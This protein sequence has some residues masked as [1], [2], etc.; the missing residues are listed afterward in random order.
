METLKVSKFERESHYTWE[1][2]D[3]ISQNIIMNQNPGLYP[4]HIPLRDD[5]GN[6]FKPI[7]T[8]RLFDLRGRDNKRSMLPPRMNNGDMIETVVIASSH[9]AGKHFEISLEQ[10]KRRD[11]TF[12]RSKTKVEDREPAQ[13]FIPGSIPP[14]PKEEVVKV[15]FHT[16]SQTPN[17]EILA[18]DTETGR[19]VSTRIFAQELAW[20]TDRVWFNVNRYEP[21]GTVDRTQPSDQPANEGEQLIERMSQSFQT[22]CIYQIA[23]VLEPPARKRTWGGIDEDRLN[24]IRANPDT[25]RVLDNLI[26]CLDQDEFQFYFTSKSGKGYQERWETKFGPYMKDLFTLAKHFRNFWFYRWQ[27]ID[28]GLP[29]RGQA[30]LNPSLPEVDFVIPRWLVTQWTITEY[31]S[32]DGEVTFS[33]PKPYTWEPFDFPKDGYPSPDESAFLLKLSIQAEQDRQL[34]ELKALVQSNSDGSKMFWFRGR[35]RSLDNKERIYAVEVYLGMDAQLVDKGLNMPTP[36]TR[37]HLEVDR[38][39]AELPTRENTAK[40]DGVVVYDALETSASFICVVDIVG[41]ALTIADNDLEYNM[42]ISYIVDS[43]PYV[44]MLNGVAQ[45]QTFIGN[46]LGPDPRKTILDCRL[47]TENTDNQNREISETEF[48]TFRNVVQEIPPI[49]NEIQMKAAV[50]TLES[51][52]GNVVIVGPPGTGKTKT[53]LKICHGHAKLGRRIILS[54]PTNSTVHTLVDGF[55]ENNKK[56]RQDNQYQDH[57]WV[58]FTGGY[59]SVA[60]AEEL[61]QQ[62]QGGDEVLQRA[63][64]KLFSYLLDAQNRRHIPRYEQTLGYKLAKRIGVWASDENYDLSEHGKLYSDARSYLDTRQK[65]S[66]IQDK[67]QRKQAKKHIRALEYNLSIVFL[68][69]VKFCFCTLSTSGHEL[70]AESGNWD[71]LIID[72]AARETR[73]GLAVALGSLAGRIKLVVW[74]GDHKQG[75]APVMGKNMNIGH[76]LLSRNVFA[77][78]AD[79]GIGDTACEVIMLEEC[80]RMQKSLIKLPSDWCYDGKVRSHPSAGCTEMPLRNMLRY[81]WKARLANDF[82]GRWTDIALDVTHKDAKDEL[83]PGTTTRR[84]QLEAKIVALTMLD[85]LRMECPA[86]DYST[87]S[88]RRILPSDIR[89]VTNYTGQL[90]CIKSAMKKAAAQFKLNPQDL[91]GIIYSTTSN[92]RGKESNIVFYST[93]IASG[94]LRLQADDHIPIGFVANLEN[95]S[96][97]L[98]RCRIARYTIGAF[99]LFNQARKDHHNVSKNKNHKAFFQFVEALANSGSIVSYGEST[100]WFKNGTK[101]ANFVG[102]KGTLQQ[103]SSNKQQ[104]AAKKPTRRGKAGG[105]QRRE[106]ELAEA[107]ASGDADADAA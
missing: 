74:A 75:E 33:D 60:K 78:L 35:F 53:L 29:E 83:F 34:R 37:I 31:T 18:F 27:C 45:L 97:S 55:I 70:L 105:K 64:E 77:A 69:E 88:F 58:Y 5:D 104:P 106:R 84:N 22:T 48:A 68:S 61:A 86:K 96:V 63:N 98:T 40:L 15:M 102:L 20:E 3:T 72:E 32:P 94:T 28:A 23:V 76:K 16:D 30:I 12:I 82:S 39:N 1:E 92:V 90:L 65:L 21:D 50:Q 66:A 11:I 13:P 4:E 99:S 59:T 81:Y 57:E 42:F 54:A 89:V 62:Q 101:P 93:T 9:F 17:I 73:A 7:P 67:V 8:T 51:S 49:A 100:Q 19:N 71:V 80:Y 38:V 44:R 41:Q 95:L 56:L 2:L 52:S 107:S 36:G 25:T 91:E 46:D 47:P 24:R 87:S 26:S 6:E 43:T 85:M 103:A 79:A 10:A 14:P